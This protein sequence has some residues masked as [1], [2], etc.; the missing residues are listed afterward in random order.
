MSKKSTRSANIRPNP[1]IKLINKIRSK[2]VK[3]RG[4]KTLLNEKIEDEKLLLLICNN[5]CKISNPFFTVCQ[6]NDID[7]DLLALH[8]IGE[9]EIFHHNCVSN[10]I[11]DNRALVSIYEK[12][13]EK[14]Y[15]MDNSKP[16]RT[17][18]I[19]GSIMQN[20]F[21]NEE[22][23]M[24]LSLNGWKLD[25]QQNS[26]II[27]RILNKKIYL[28]KQKLLI[29]IMAPSNSFQKGKI[30]W[31]RK[32]KFE[33]VNHI[34]HY[35]YDESLGKNLSPREF[36][37]KLTAF[38]VAICYVIPHSEILLI[39]PLKRRQFSNS[40]QC[41]ECVSFDENSIDTY[42]D[43]VENFIKL[44]S[45]ITVDIKSRITVMKW[46]KIANLSYGTNLGFLNK[47]YFSNDHVHLTRLGCEFLT[48]VLTTIAE[49]RLNRKNN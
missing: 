15:M 34:S 45:M 46:D 48:S 26:D 3:F 9:I 21:F 25:T 32:R 8:I 13:K 49:N 38:L 42:I 1:F 27:N 29:V 14:F 22:I 6:V 2:H 19:G 12:N 35:H 11:I 24:N 33:G 20:L 17:I 10:E 31:D 28:D 5:G 7:I 18:F 23:F 40:M 43:T 41:I 4:Y 37:E 47:A 36:S 44:N 30:I 39:P 16:I